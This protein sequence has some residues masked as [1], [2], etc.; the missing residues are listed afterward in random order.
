[1]EGQDKVF[2]GYLKEYEQ[3]SE[4]YRHTYATIWQ[5]GALFGVVSG[6]IVGLSSRNGSLA[7]V[8]QVLAPL[9]LLFW[10][11]GIFR[12]MNHYGEMRS[13]RLAQLEELLADHVPG[14]EMRHFRSYDIARKGE[15]RMY[16]VVTFKWIWR[17]RVTEI[18]TI[19]GI[20]LLT[21]EI[22]LISSNL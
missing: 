8:I 13:E 21:A 11:A 18:V 17:P 22:V 1:M 4:S 9:P 2:D 10:Y 5:A 15:S 7:P 20:L 14:L 6:A 12:P 3:C 19:V 16:R